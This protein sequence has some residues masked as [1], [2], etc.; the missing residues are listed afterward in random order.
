MKLS[1]VFV[2]ICLYATSVFC[3][4]D[5]QDMYQKKKVSGAAITI[6]ALTAATVG[7]ILMVSNR[8]SAYSYSGDGR[9]GVGFSSPAGGIGFLITLSA[10][11]T[12]IVGLTKLVKG[13]RGLREYSY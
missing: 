9:A 13:R 1:I 5:Y 2:S 8:N 12:T 6:C 3:Q 11:P 4:D 7:T 10:I